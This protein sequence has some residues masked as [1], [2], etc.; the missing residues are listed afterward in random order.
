MDAGANRA[1]TLTGRGG[2]VLARIDTRTFSV[3]AA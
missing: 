1:L 2:P 3:Q